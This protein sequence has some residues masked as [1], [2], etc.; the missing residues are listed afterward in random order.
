[1]TCNLCDG[2]CRT[3]GLDELLTAE[4]AWL[5][6]TVAA[7]ADRRGDA[8]M[9][10]GS[11]TVVAPV[12]AASRAAAAGLLGRRHL[13][14]GQR[15][16][17]DLAGL[18][19]RL[20]PLTPGAAAVHAVGR[21]LAA[22]AAAVASRADAEAALRRA[23]WVIR[24]CNAGRPDIVDDSAAVLARLPGPGAPRVDRRILAQAAT[25]SPHALDTGRLLAGFTLAVAAATGR[26]PSA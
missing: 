18:A 24:V 17:V 19:A 21:P 22:R 7:A 8:V 15:V 6:A 13:H 11:T 5:W 26:I 10:S 25:G 20:A 3:A 9:V 4:L 14:A 12:D 16:R 23:G 2:T 1:M